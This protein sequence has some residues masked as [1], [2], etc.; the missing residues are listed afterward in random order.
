[1]IRE[2][3]DQSIF[4]VSQYIRSE[5]TKSGIDKSELSYSN[6]IGEI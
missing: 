5:I 2:S 1:M 6:R 4:K 3:L